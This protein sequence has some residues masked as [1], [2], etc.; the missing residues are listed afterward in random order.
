MKTKLI[1]RKFANEEARLRNEPFEVVVSEGNMGTALGIQRALDLICGGTVAGTDVG[2]ATAPLPWKYG[3][4]T[5]YSAIGVG[6]V[7]SAESA[8]AT[9]WSDGTGG[10]H[11]MD[12]TAYPSRSSQTVS[13]KSTFG[14]TEA[15]FAWNEFTIF[16][17]TTL[18]D[19]TARMLIRKVSV[20]G[21]KISGQSWE[22]TLAITMS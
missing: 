6:T 11:P 17:S 3:L 9:T 18:T 15:N 20:Q 2:G 1:T 12:S 19:T 8:T 5:V 10:L 21:T 14:G 7:T 13:W 16:Q 4:G 22:C